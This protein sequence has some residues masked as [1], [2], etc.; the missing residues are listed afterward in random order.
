MLDEFL[1][2]WVEKGI[3]TVGGCGV[4]LGC[5]YGVHGRDVGLADMSRSSLSVRL[6]ELAIS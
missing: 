2:G 5:I 4:V 1:G 6:Q 3:D